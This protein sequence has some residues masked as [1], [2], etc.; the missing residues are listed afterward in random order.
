MLPLTA[1]KRKLQNRLKQNLPGRD[2]Q[3]R[4]TGRHM[5]AAEEV[6]E[7]VRLSAVLVLLFVQDEEVKLLFIQRTDDGG[8]H[9]GQI[10]FPGGSKDEIDV[11]L[12]ATALREAEEEVG[13]NADQV[14]MLGALSPLY[15]PVSNFM[16]YPFVAWCNTP[17]PYSL[18]TMEVA[19]VLEVPLGWMRDAKTKIQT[20]VRPA[21]R[22]GLV[23]DVPGYQLPGDLL[24]W[25]ATAMIFAELEACLD[26]L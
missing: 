14:D 16:V 21:S 18:S 19:A 11:S 15:I 12:E 3:L 9:S 1:F 17:V 7:D 10:S 6:P 26:T 25:G 4:M 23:L 24:L 22:P 8:A 5:P 2:A 13:L 20:T